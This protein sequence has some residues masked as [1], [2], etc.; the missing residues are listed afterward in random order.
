MLTEAEKY[1]FAPYTYK[2][3]RE[4]ESISLYLDKFGTYQLNWKQAVFLMV[5]GLI[6]IL[7]YT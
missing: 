2:M 5:K 1:S 6:L 3:R 7:T 4:E